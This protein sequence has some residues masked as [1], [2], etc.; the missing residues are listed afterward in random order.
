MFL[1][2]LPS[3]FWPAFPPVK[4]I[5]IMKLCYTLKETAILYVEI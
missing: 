4:E 1:K 3:C 2:I 5:N